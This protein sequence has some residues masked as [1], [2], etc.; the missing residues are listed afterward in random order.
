MENPATA[1]ATSESQ[2]R[3]EGFLPGMRNWCNSSN[4]GKRRGVEQMKMMKA[5]FL[6][7]RAFQTLER[8]KPQR[9]YI[10]K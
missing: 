8:V 10:K 2:S 6:G 5:V 1:P 9:K 7:D 3:K 4:A